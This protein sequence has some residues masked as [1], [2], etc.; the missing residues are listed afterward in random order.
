MWYEWIMILT[1]ERVVV[2]PVFLPYWN[3]WFFRWSWQKA[4][5]ESCLEVFFSVVV[6]CLGRGD[7]RDF[8]CHSDKVWVLEHQNSQNFPCCFGH[9]SLVPLFFGVPGAKWWVLSFDSWFLATW[10]IIPVSKWLGSPPFRS[11]GVRPSEKVG[12]SPVRG[13]TITMVINHWT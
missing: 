9:E 13:L 6:C 10:R 11:H 7:L 4:C 5:N 2:N 8:P 3:G 1:Y 12:T